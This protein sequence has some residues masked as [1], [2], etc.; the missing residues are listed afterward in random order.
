MYPIIRTSGQHICEDVRQIRERCQHFSFQIS[1]LRDLTRSYKKTTFVS[2]VTRS[3][4]GNGF[5]LTEMKCF[6]QALIHRPLH[7]LLAQP[8]RQAICLPLGLYRGLSQ[9]VAFKKHGNFHRSHEHTMHCDLHRIQCRRGIPQS[10]FGSDNHTISYHTDN[11]AATKMWPCIS[12]RDPR[13]MND[14][15]RGKEIKWSAMQDGLTCKGSDE[16][17]STNARSDKKQTKTVWQ[18]TSL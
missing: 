4:L 10:I 6:H 7:S 12:L 1:Q 8:E 17:I 2:L 13:W 15:F 11:P 14:S 5:A 18:C 16:F 3:P 9:S